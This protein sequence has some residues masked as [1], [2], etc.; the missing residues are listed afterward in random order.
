MNKNI[1]TI[2]ELIRLPGM[3]TAHADI[4]AGFLLAGVRLKELD[5]FFC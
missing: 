3:F 5:V 1:K 2:F 4:L